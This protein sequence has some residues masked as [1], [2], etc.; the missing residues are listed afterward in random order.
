M[1][2]RTIHSHERKYSQLDKE[3]TAIMFGI[4]KFHNYLMGRSFS[5]I[6]TDHKPLVS[7]F[8]PKKPIPNII[9]PRLT[10]ISI[11][12]TSHSFKIVY[13]PGQQIGNADGLSRWPQPVP[14]EFEE[15]L[16]DFLLM[17]E[18]PKDFPVDIQQ[19]EGHH[20]LSGWP[21]KVTE[22]ELRI[23][24]LHRNELSIHTNHIAA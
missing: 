8:D 5:I 9:S 6:V 21:P 7:I 2:S 15:Q 22:E 3:A 20:I 13:K 18:A 12:L 11:V 1:S 14:E 24:W 4:R 16:R 19:I 23:Y 17:A 10:R